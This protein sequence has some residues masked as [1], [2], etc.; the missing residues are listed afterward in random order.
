MCNQ[1]EQGQKFLMII[2]C[3]G[4]FYYI[5]FSEIGSLLR[6]YCEEFQ[7]N[8]VDVVLITVV[9]Q[10]QQHKNCYVKAASRTF[11]LNS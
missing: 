3:Y 9:L 5:C 8:T 4:L 6:A 2:H 1:I 7:S 10:F 11:I